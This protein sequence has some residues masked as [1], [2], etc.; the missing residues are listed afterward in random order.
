MG[1]VERAVHHDVGDG[2]EAARAQIFGARDEVSGGIVDEIG[3]RARGK[4]V[5]HHGVDRGSVADIDAV[6][7]DL[8][9]M[10]AYQL[11]GGRF[12]HRFA[13]SANNDVGAEL[14]KLFG[15]PLAEP[16][17]AAGDEDAPAAQQSILEHDPRPHDVF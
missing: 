10:L 7:A 11:G 2:V 12:A 13:A 1:D 4:D 8:A 16:G 9:A 14:K 6:D 5:G 17:A 15:H 3:E